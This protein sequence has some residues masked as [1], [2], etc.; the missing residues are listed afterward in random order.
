MEL[1][2]AVLGSAIGG[3]VEVEGLEEEEEI[4]EASKA[5]VPVRAYFFSTR[6]AEIFIRILDCMIIEFLTV[7]MAILWQC[8]FEKFGGAE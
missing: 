7:F 1:D 4:V 2:D 3:G 6:S 5:Y 8:G